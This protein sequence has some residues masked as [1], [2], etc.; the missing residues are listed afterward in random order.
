ML[1]AFQMASDVGAVIGPI[2]AGMIVERVS[3]G[4]AFAVTGALLLLA[5]L[6]WSR[7]PDTLERERS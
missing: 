1:A 3:F 7:V 5:G 2:V 6:W 4:P